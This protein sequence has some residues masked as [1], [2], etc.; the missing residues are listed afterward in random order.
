M[1]I[2]LVALILTGVCL[3]LARSQT[4]KA[5]HKFK[6]DPGTCGRAF[7]EKWRGVVYSGPPCNLARVW[8]FCIG[9]AIVSGMVSVGSAIVFFFR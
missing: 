8:R 6:Q 9:V 2:S 1:V 7:P 3:N 5:E 4:L